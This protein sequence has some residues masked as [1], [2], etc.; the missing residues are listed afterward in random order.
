MNKSSV[1]IAVK[2]KGSIALVSFIY[3][4]EI[5]PVCNQE[6]DS[7]EIDVYCVIT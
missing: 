3:W 5:S 7:A 4:H 6:D 2:L 1:I